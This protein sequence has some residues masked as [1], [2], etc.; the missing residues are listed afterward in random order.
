MVAISATKKKTIAG[1]SGYKL[2]Y[3]AENDDT[4]EESRNLK[5]MTFR[6]KKINDGLVGPLNKPGLGLPLFRFYIPC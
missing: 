2:C 1:G 6:I 3:I 5:G 4:M